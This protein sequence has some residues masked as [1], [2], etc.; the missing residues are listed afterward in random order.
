MID[1]PSMAHR[2]LITTRDEVKLEIV[3]QL[4]DSLL[5][6]AEFCEL[7]L[8]NTSPLIA[9]YFWRDYRACLYQLEVVGS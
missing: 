3:Q 4:G 2:F 7:A 1:V 6:H 8:K 5:V 9:G